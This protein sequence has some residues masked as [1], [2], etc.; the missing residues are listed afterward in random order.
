MR[1]SEV[2]VSPL[3][4][5]PPCL[6]YTLDLSRYFYLS[7][8]DDI[9]HIY[10][11]EVLENEN[12]QAAAIKTIVSDYVWRHRIK[13]ILLPNL[14]DGL[15]N[16]LADLHEAI[17][18]DM[19]DL[20]RQ[21]SK[22]GLK[23]TL[24]ELLIASIDR[25]MLYLYQP[26]GAVTGNRFF[27]RDN[28]LRAILRHHDRSC[29]VSG[30]RMSGK[31]SLLLEAKRRLEIG[32]KKSDR[33]ETVYVD[34]KKYGTAAGLISAILEGLGE[35]TSFSSED[36]WS[37]PHKLAEFAHFLRDY[38]KS[39]PSKRLHI[40]LDEYDGVLMLEKAQG[41]K[42]TWNFRSLVTSNNREQGYIQ[43]ILAGT[44]MLAAEVNRVGSDLY[45]FPY[46]EGTRLDNFDVGTIKNIL[47][48][49]FHDLGFSIDDPQGLSQAIL[50]E[51]AGRPSSVQYVCEQL[52]LV[53]LKSE[54]TQAL[55]ATLSSIVHSPQY[56][57]FYEQSLQEN[58][59]DLERLI[60][61]AQSHEEASD[62]FDAED[63]RTKCEELS[64]HVESVQISRSLDDLETSGFLVLDNASHSHVR[65]T[66]AVPVIRKIFRRRTPGS[67][68]PSIIRSGTG[69]KI[70]AM[71]P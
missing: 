36:R 17:L 23:Q 55:E 3:V 70:D 24:R 19:A 8:V 37:Y 68:V 42:L 30:N 4:P 1:L 49:P 52:V 12:D 63:V 60:L 44:K 61:C 11:P 29:L 15:R 66:I 13:L 58:T 32:A 14:T 65:Y 67:Y 35:R 28:Q 38:V 34:C 47:T 64:L 26:Q 7:S 48:L 59:N 27:G 57:R 25:M 39:L 69:T 50:H 41:H 5:K 71:M 33:P 6:I 54:S 20:Q 53:L 2:E 9:A 21:I 46:E 16:L 45:K 18:L 31:T 62:S 22:E 56:L 10:L 40:F 43:F 51:T